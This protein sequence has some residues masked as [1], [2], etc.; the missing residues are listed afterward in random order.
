MDPVTAVGLAGSVAQLADLA[1]SVVSNMWQYCRAV[2]DAPNRSR[3]LRLEMCVICDLLESLENAMINSRFP[4]T[5][6][7][8]L[9]DSINGFQA[10]LNKMKVRIAESQTKGLSR[11]KWPF[12][13]TE[14]KRLISSIERYKGS[15][16]LA[17]NI[18]TV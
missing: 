13:E 8:S 2:Q 6:P 3:E 14:N 16:S 15:F 7:V 10:L 4:S 9:K 5:A 12:T 18:Q 17:L 1:R 11:L